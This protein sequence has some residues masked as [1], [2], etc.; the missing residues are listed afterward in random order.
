MLAVSDIHARGKRHRGRRRLH[1]QHRTA[2]QHSAGDQ[3]PA[4]WGGDQNKTPIT[5][6]TWSALSI[7]PICD[8]RRW[9]YSA[10]TSRSE[11]GRKMKFIISLRFDVSNCG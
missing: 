7:A 1:R 2:D 9:R 3:H 8:V 6:F 10:E 4:D 5:T 11:R